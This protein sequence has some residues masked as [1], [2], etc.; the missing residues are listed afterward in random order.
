MKILY[1]SVEVAPYAKVGGLADVAE[2]L[3][4]AL[5]EA[6]HDVRVAC[7]AYGMAI[8]D[9]ALHMRHRHSLEVQMN[10]IW[11]ET[12]DHYEGVNSGVRTWLLGNEKNFAWV[13]RSEDLYSHG[14]DSYLLFARAIMAACEAEGWIPDVISCND[15]QTAFLPVF[16]REL[17]GD[18]WA[19]VACTYTIHNLAYQGEFGADTLPSAGLSPELF[20][21]EKLEFF[22]RVNFLKSACMFADIVN[23][24]SPKYAEEIQTERYGCGLWGVMQSL[25]STGRLRGILNGIDLDRFDPE[26]DEELEA[27]YTAANWRDKVQNKRELQGELDWAVD[28][29]MPLLAIVSRLSDQKGFDLL[30]KAMPGI[31]N[32]PSQLVIL[33][34]GDPHAASQLRQLQAEW[35]DRL[36]LVERFDAPLAQRIYGAADI[37]LMPSHFEPCGLGQLIAMRY[38]SVPV[39][40][41]TGGLANTVF[42]GK[43]GFAYDEAAVRPMLEAISR[44]V[45]TYKSD[46]KTWAKLVE[47]GMAGDYGWRAPAEEYVKMYADAIAARAKSAAQAPR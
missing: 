42:E 7:P 5:V 23:T 35:P 1:V 21:G 14:R 10:P 17:G 11:E 18:K 27:K 25:S 6:G 36:R 28:D 40:R 24:V 3:P 20:T 16:V 2:G 31:L 38:G 26:H 4:K 19:N 9:P 22:G 8:A 33:A 44:A 15:W 45:E 43:N 32:L 41:M 29:D 46:A 37:F 47:A 30:V 39:A 34:V 12:V 13:H